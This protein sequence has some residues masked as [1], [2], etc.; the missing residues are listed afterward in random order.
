[1]NE[2]LKQ[3]FTPD[4]VVFFRNSRKISSY[5]IRSNLYPVERL[6]GSLNCK[7]PRCQI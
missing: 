3:L 7:R 1:M 2:E 6:V 4:P 5:L